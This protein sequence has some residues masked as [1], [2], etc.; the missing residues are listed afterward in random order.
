MKLCQL[1][2]TEALYIQTETYYSSR[3][4]T[5]QTVEYTPYPI[6]L[7]TSHLQWYTFALIHRV[8]ANKPVCAY[9]FLMVGLGEQEIFAPWY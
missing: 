6:L 9:P 5:S 2:E 4:R 3:S 7:R 1:R 8:E